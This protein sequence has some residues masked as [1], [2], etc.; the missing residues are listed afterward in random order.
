MFVGF[1][2]KEAPL[3][4]GGDCFFCSDQEL[5][6]TVAERPLLKGKAA[7]RVFDFLSYFLTCFIESATLLTHILVIG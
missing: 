2:E 3:V 4:A 1:T 7:D 6:C 5:A